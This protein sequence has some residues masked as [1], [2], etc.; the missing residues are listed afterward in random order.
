MLK[1]FCNCEKNKKCVGIHRYTYTS[2]SLSWSRFVWPIR[3]FRGQFIL[4]LYSLICNRVNL[5]SCMYLIGKIRIP[6]KKT[7]RRLAFY[8]DCVKRDILSR[9]Y[10]NVSGPWK[11]SLEFYW[12]N[13]KLFNMT[14][15]LLCTQLSHYFN[16]TYL[17]LFIG[18]R[19]VYAFTK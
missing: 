16:K 7:R 1:C 8:Y 4:V 11:S 3:T 15:F 18:F 5:Q 13:G 10:N 6:F 9:I 12:H 19:L 2:K 17:L 14:Q